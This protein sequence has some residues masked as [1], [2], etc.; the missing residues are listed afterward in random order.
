MSS[1]SSRIT[2]PGTSSS[3]LT[4]GSVSSQ[5]AGA[6]PAGTLASPPAPRDRLVP[7]RR[8]ARDLDTDESPCPGRP[9]LVDSPLGHDP[10]A[11][12]HRHPIAD[13]LHA[14]PLMT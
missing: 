9:E 2:P 14:L 11:D 3:R 8:R 5:S 6:P 4:P 10:A 1:A 7:I 12:D 13:A